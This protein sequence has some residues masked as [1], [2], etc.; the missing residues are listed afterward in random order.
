MKSI[1]DKLRQ[2]R[3]LVREVT[4]AL[5]DDSL[6][7]SV[8]VGTALASVVRLSNDALTGIKSTFRTAALDQHQG[9]AGTRTFEGLDGRQVSVA[10][11]SPTL[12]LLKSTDMDRLRRSL[13]DEFEK[14]FET[15]VTYK[16]RLGLGERIMA[17]PASDTK[18]T[19]LLALE[20]VEGTPRVS[21][22]KP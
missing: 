12:R 4:D 22:P 16:P 18:N 1:Q 7:D 21:F 8:E 10:V 19:L 17:L 14:F 11:P 15:K 6:E 5:T 2:I 20:E 9:R 3:T 13:G